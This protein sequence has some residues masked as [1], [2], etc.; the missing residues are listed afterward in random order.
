MKRKTLVGHGTDLCWDVPLYAM[1]STQTR[2]VEPGTY[3]ICP[4]EHVH[5]LQ[6]QVT[7][8]ICIPLPPQQLPSCH[9]RLL[10]K[11]C[12]KR[13]SVTSRAMRWPGHSASLY[14]GPSH[15]ER[16]LSIFRELLPLDP[17]TV[18]PESI[19][20]ISSHSATLISS[21]DSLCHATFPVPQPSVAPYW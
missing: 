2:P 4:R 5:W 1:R 14:S 10:W 20:S 19:P 8:L 9:P 11:Q 3:R 13:E 7:I 18:T 15:H 6:E 16:C 21:E 12:G 17:S